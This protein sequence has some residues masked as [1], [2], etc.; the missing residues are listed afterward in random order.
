MVLSCI[1]DGTKK[2]KEVLSNSL[3]AGKSTTIKIP[4]A[5]I[6]ENKLK[7][8]KTNSVNRITESN[9]KNNSLKTR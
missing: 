5:K 1:Y 9:K 6:C 3:G 8:F 4:I 2:I 7:T